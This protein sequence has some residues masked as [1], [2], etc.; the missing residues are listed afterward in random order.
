[1]A[2]NA[3]ENEDVTKLNFFVN[4]ESDIESVCKNLKEQFKD[5]N[6]EVEQ[7]FNKVLADSG[8]NLKTSNEIVTQL[9][10]QMLGIG[11]TFRDLADDKVKNAAR[12]DDED[13]KSVKE[14]QDGLDGI[15]DTVGEKNKRHKKQNE[16]LEKDNLLLGQQSQLL[17]GINNEIARSA[18]ELGVSTAE[19]SRGVKLYEGMLSAIYLADRATQNFITTNYRLYDSQYGLAQ[20]SREL[21]LQTGMSSSNAIKAVKALSDMSTPK[22]QMAALAK[23]ILEANNYLGV[24]IDRLAEFSRITRLAGG[25]VNAFNRMMLYSSEVM[26]KYGLTTSEVEASLLLTSTAVNKVAIAFG[27][28]AGTTRD[29]NGKLITSFEL[30]NQAR[31]EYA[32]AAKAIGED[33]KLMSEALDAFLDPNKFYIFQGEASRLAMA[34]KTPEERMRALPAIVDNVAKEFQIPLDKIN[35]MSID[36]AIKSAML[37]PAAEYLGITEDQYLAQLR[38]SEAMK[39]TG[40]NLSDITQVDAFLKAKN[41]GIDPFNESMY[42]LTGL[43]EALSSKFDALYDIINST[44]G[45]GIMEIYLLAK[46]A[47]D[48][49][50]EGASL[51]IG[52]FKDFAK[53]NPLLA[54]SI[55]MVASGL[56]VGTVAFA[57]MSKAITLTKNAMSMLNLSFKILNL[58]P[59]MLAI[60]LVVLGFVA[61]YESSEDFRYMIKSLTDYIKEFKSV[62]T[63]VRETIIG[64]KIQINEFLDLHPV[65]GAFFKSLLNPGSLAKIILLGALFKTLSGSMGSIFNKLSFGFLKFGKSSSTAASSV[66][67]SGGLISKAFDGLI[68]IFGRVLN[69]IKDLVVQLLKAIQEIV[70]GVMSIIDEIAKGIN[71]VL[72]SITNNLDPKRL[73]AIGV[74]SVSFYV[75]AQAM[76]VFVD[77]ASRVAKDLGPMLVAMASLTVAIALMGV[78]LVALGSVAQGPVLLGI[79]AVAAGIL[80]LSAAAYVA[81]LAFEV[82]APAFKIVIDTL[83]GAD[84]GNIIKTFAALAGG[85]VLLGV[86]SIVAP[87]IITASGALLLLTGAIL[88]FNKVMP[89]LEPIL[90]LASKA[91]DTFASLFIKSLDAVERVINKVIESMESLITSLSGLGGMDVLVLAGLGAALFAF[92][93]SGLL[94]VPGLMALSAALYYLAPK[95]SDIVESL[96]KYAQLPA[97][98]FKNLANDLSNSSNL[99]SNM[100]NTITA[101]FGTAG[102]AIS[103]FFSGMS[104]EQL[105]SKAQIL[106]FFG[107]TIGTA[108]Q[109]ISSG[110]TSLVGSLNDFSSLDIAAATDKAL[111]LGGLASAFETLG[112]DLDAASATIVDPIN[113]VTAAV[114]RLNE[115]VVEFTSN[116]S[117]GFSESFAS[118]KDILERGIK[119]VIAASLNTGV[120]PTEKVGSEVTVKSSDT[121]SK[122]IEKLEE[123]RV[124]NKENDGRII[125]LLDEQVTLVKSSERIGT[126]YNLWVS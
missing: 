56:L 100:S 117:S 77:A 15:V 52:A 66:S 9:S 42:T 47:L 112:S 79:A 105:I 3:A 27:K 75:L 64:F 106:K 24:S 54:K 12:F 70:K 25:D 1:M 76:S 94:S 33:S 16:L 83:S 40:V 84:A 5:L 44:L 28:M 48:L 120:M 125:N 14:L 29:A 78:T 71:K 34:F 62:L 68:G 32:G 38:L 23:T 46:P 7:N 118:L 121:D 73:L 107:D 36:P 2:D 98:I 39:Q 50:F 90:K 97:G 102:A 111:G 11:E 126:N 49:M 108:S 59:T 19:L 6:D 82:F 55:R 96:A 116:I 18:K 43:L 109:S 21:T 69:A 57:S 88:A 10:E 124:Q 101:A 31:L 37:K 58:N 26:R 63:A 104:P 113:L 41:Q 91:I 13:L 80:V 119:P 35:D 123:L 30:F 74:L 22:G 110:V 93:V 95:I 4:F 89:G 20:Q 114:S 99:M 65:V 122:L 115:A 86:S 51:I 85:M 60:S 17:D 45:K 72:I 8:T 81:A 61:L 92:S 67:K 103:G 87:G 53:E